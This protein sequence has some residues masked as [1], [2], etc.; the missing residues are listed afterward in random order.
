MEQLGAFAVAGEPAFEFQDGAFQA[1]RPQLAGEDRC[2]QG[3]EDRG[4]EVGDRDRVEPPRQEG[5]GGQPGELEQEVAAGKG[6]HGQ[7]KV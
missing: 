1:P 4:I 5:N 7:E 2:R 3:P 6:G